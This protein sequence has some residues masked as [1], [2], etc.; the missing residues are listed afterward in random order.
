MGIYAV[1]YL[2]WNWRLVLS[3]FSQL[4]FLLV[5]GF[6]LLLYCFFSFFLF[7]IAW[8]GCI[9]CFLSDLLVFFC[10]RLQFIDSPLDFTYLNFGFSFLDHSLKHLISPLYLVIIALFRDFL[11]QISLITPYLMNVLFKILLLFMLLLYSQFPSFTI[12]KNI[13]IVMLTMRLDKLSKLLLCSRSEVCYFVR[14][15]VVYQYCFLA[16]SECEVVDGGHF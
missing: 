9:F 15:A 7:F 11:K 5:K 16:W 6:K 4:L 3:I 10:V 8:L 13:D 2:F 1:Y 12:F 14:R